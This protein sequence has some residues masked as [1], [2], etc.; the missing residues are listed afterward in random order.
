[1][2]VAPRRDPDHLAHAWCG[3]ICVP[4]FLHK[5]LKQALGGPVTKRAARLRAFYAETMTAR[6]HA[7]PLEEADPVR[8]WRR[9]Y[10]ERFGGAAS[11]RLSRREL[12][13]AALILTRVGYCRHEPGCETREDCVRKIALARKVG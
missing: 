3:R 10:S 5:Q 6:P 4:T 8:F 13:D 1:L 2:L 11:T 7:T 9:A 12:E